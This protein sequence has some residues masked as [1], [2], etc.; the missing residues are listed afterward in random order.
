LARWVRGARKMGQVLAT[1]PTGKYRGGWKKERPHGFG[2]MSFVD[3]G[4][5]EGEWQNGLRHGYGM[6]R[7]GPWRSYIG[8][9]A[10]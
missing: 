4:L 2:V 1:L 3:G 10:Y 6:M 7:N 9:R 5:Y 8:A